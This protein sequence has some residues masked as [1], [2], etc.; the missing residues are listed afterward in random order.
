VYNVTPFTKK[1]SYI[2][3]FATSNLQFGGFSIA[4][5]FVQAAKKLAVNDSIPLYCH[6]PHIGN[7][8]TLFAAI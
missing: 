1:Y 7:S 4:I 8:V 2:L 3:K 6:Q 5:D